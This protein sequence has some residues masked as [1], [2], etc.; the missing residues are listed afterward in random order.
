MSSS[1]SGGRGAGAAEA[2]D[3][4]P[5]VSVVVPVLNGADLVACCLEALRRLDYPDDRHE[6]IVV[7][8]GSTDGTWEILCRYPVRALCETRRGPSYA[9]NHGI[10][11]ARGEIV[12]FMDADCVPT[13]GWL[14]ELV[15]GF[16]DPEVG[17]VAGEILPFPPET[18][19]ERYAAR[20]RHLSPER[21]LRRAIFPFAVTANLAFR[22]EVFDRIGVLD[23]ESPRG[24]ES[25][26]L[27]T[28]FFRGTGQRLALASGAIV[29]HRHRDDSWSFFKQQYGYGRGHAY[30]YI[31]YEDEIPWGWRQTGKVYADLLAA[32]LSLA[33]AGLGRLA[34]RVGNDELEFAYFE[35]LK[36]LALR[37]GFAREAASRRR[38]YL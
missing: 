14:R 9:R 23:V 34:G 20:I 28:R 1:P 10:E 27:C 30:L 6:V 21:Y 35:F 8:N 2:R 25:T 29:F 16:R 11:A 13:R 32:G 24:G 36:K 31:K 15:A 26:D 37:I 12:A 3:G 22:R 33:G 17:A 18:P 4:L 5:F 38:L 7:D 19:A